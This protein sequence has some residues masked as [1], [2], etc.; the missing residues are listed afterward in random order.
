MFTQDNYTSR[1]Y[2]LPNKEL[3]IEKIL[4]NFQK[5]AKTQYSQK[6]EKFLEREWR[7][8][9][10][11]FIQPIISEK[12]YTFKEVQTSE[13]ARLD[14]VITYFQHQYVVELKR[15]YGPA[16]HERG[17]QQLGKYLDKQ[18][19]QKGYLVIFEAT[20]NKSWKQQQM[21]FEDKDIFAIWV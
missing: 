19:Q 13:E 7:V 8:L 5:F 16:A 17:L 4:I 9:L 20:K 3:D 6:D 1:S 15:W 21:Q 10:L 14:I 12:G 18:H 2:E 11:A